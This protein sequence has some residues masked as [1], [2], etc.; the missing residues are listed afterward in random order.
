M[1]TDDPTPSLTRTIARHPGRA[2]E[3]A[4]RE[5]DGAYEIISNG[6]FLMDTRDGRS[7]RL[8]VRSAL[9]LVATEG[10]RR[11]LLGGLGVGFSLAEALASPDVGEVV[12]VEWEPA[13]VDWSRTTIGVRTGGDLDDPRV[14]CEQ[15]DLVEWLQRPSTEVFDAICLD[16]DNGPHWT[17]SPGNDW[18]YGHEGLVAIHARLAAGGVLAV[19]SAE[20]VPTF[21]RRLQGRFREVQREEVPVA[22]GGPDIV[23]L[24]FG[25][26]SA[27]RASAPLHSTRPGGSTT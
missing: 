5:R 27:H 4:L 23:Y 14:R 8:L 20:E 12:V 15:A 19:W 18:L 2:G 6:V 26:R 24:A 13:V 11:V 7:E 10:R 21:E 3:L 17:V 25:S 9:G 16:V 1:A 22:R